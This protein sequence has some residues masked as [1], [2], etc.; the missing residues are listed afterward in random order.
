M[1]RAQEAS[2]R[3][4]ALAI[5]AGLIVIGAIAFAL[6]QTSID[7][8]EWLGGSGWTLFIIG[9]G[10]LLLGAAIVAR[11][12]AAQGLTTAGSVVTAIGLLLLFMD[13]TGKWESWAYA[14]TIIPGAV[15][16]SL[17]IHGLRVGRS[18][19]RT[20]GIRLIGIATA[21]LVV[22]GWYFETIFRTG[23]APL[24]FSGIWPL[25]LIVIGG[26]VIAGSMLRRTSEPMP[27]G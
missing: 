7:V 21:L 24:D 5:G 10:V 26:V 9:P 12:S 18:D 19:L 8:T 6:Q 1:T 3:D 23:R 25:F 4:G 20:A 17:L 2:R 22:G 14:W 13:Q 15:G 27:G 11:T 16:I